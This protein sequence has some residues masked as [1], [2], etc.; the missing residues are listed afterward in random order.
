MLFER[1][2]G[3]FGMSVF[4]S[5][6]R[7][8]LGG[9][10]LREALLLGPLVVVGGSV[11]LEDLGVLGDEILAAVGADGHGLSGLDG[12]AV[13]VNLDTSAGGVGLLVLA[14]D[15]VLLGDRHG[16]RWWWLYVLRGVVAVLCF[17]IVWERR[18]RRKVGRSRFRFQELWKTL[19][20]FY[21]CR[22]E[23]NFW[24]R[25]NTTARRENALAKLEVRVDAAPHLNASPSLVLFSH[26]GL[27]L[28]KC[29]RTMAK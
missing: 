17:V 24:S 25:S 2:K 11:L 21:F 12:S 10:L 28:T 20:L 13:L 8:H 27:S 1:S 9:E 3:A 26:A 7:E 18:G 6:S 22:V 15:A 23:G 16:E 4:F 14:G 5:S 19:S 29:I